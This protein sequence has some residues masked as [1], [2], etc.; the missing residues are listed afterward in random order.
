VEEEKLRCMELALTSPGVWRRKGATNKAMAEVIEISARRDDLARFSAR[1]VPQIFSRPREEWYAVVNRDPRYVTQDAVWSALKSA[2]AAISADPRKA[3]AIFSWCTFVAD[4]LCSIVPAHD[5]RAEAWKNYGW[6]LRFFGDYAAAGTALDAAEESAAL[7]DDDGRLLASVRLVRASLYINLERYDEA[8][9]ILSEAREIFER[10]LDLAGVVKTLD[11]EA[12]ARMKMGDVVSARILLRRVIAE[13]SH[14]DEDLARLFLNVAHASELAGDLREAKHALS[15]AI[16]LHKLCGAR[17]MQ[18]MDEWELGR[19]HLANGDLNA[20]CESI[21]H[22]HAEFIVAGNHD[23]AIR[24]A[25]ELSAI[26]IENDIASEGTYQRLIDCATFAVERNLPRA[27]YQALH[28]LQRLGEAV[29]AG[30]IRF[31]SAWIER[32]E[33]G[34]QEFTPPEN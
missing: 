20:A 6:L 11:I 32:F 3:L 13:H 7:L 34:P 26:E 10:L 1:E 29:T 12:N 31:I 4:R 23:S 30:K 14:S 15:E 21:G 8:V 16:R 2:D 28:Y 17:F 5:V 27:K 33:S 22:A 9:L 18:A 25:L 24:S 19:I